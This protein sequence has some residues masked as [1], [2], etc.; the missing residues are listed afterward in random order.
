M[1]KIIVTN[2]PAVPGMNIVE[3]YGIVC[4]STVRGKNVFRDIAASLKNVVGGELKGYTELMI[5]ARDLATS[6]MLQ[7]ATDLG[8]NAVINVRYST[9]NIAEG[10]AEIYVYGTAVLVS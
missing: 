7:Q 6:R 1:S 8:A 4:G 5:E 3:H 10:A 9:S 2:L